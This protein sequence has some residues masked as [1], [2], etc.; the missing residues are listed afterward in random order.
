MF[1]EAEPLLTADDAEDS[2]CNDKYDTQRSY[3][4]KCK[5]NLKPD[6]RPERIPKK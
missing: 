1:E 6:A 5:H 4:S 2:I 3:G